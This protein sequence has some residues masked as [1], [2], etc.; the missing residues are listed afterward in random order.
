MKVKPNDDDLVMGWWR[1]R[2]PL[3]R[4]TS[5]RYLREA[6]GED[7]ALLEQVRSYVEWEKRGKVSSLSH[8]IP[9]GSSIIPSSPANCSKIGSGSFARWH[10]AGWESSMRPSMRSS[11]DDRPEMRKGRFSKRLPPEVRNASD[12]SHPNVCKIFEDSHSV[13]RNGD[14][15]FSD[16]GVSRRRDTLGETSQ[17]GHARQREARVIA[18]QLCA[19]LAEAHRKHVIHGDLKR[20]IS[21]GE[22]RV[23]K[24]EP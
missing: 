9:E 12:I 1:G 7:P 22:R 2:S 5:R 19:G 15:R 6:C 10:K 17:R 8:S 18:L 4:M 20:T 3:R 11:I 24:P 23:M 21:S 13:N 16:D 14:I